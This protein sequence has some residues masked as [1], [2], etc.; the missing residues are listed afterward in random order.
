MLQDENY[1]SNEEHSE[2]EEE[3]IEPFLTMNEI[4]SCSISNW[5]NLFDGKT[6]NKR[7]TLLTKIL[8]LPDDFINYLLQDGVTLPKSLTNDYIPNFSSDSEDEKEKYKT[9]NSEEEE[10]L[11]APEFPKLQFEISEILESYE[12]IF[13]KLN[14][15]AP[16]DAQFMLSESK[17][18]KCSS[19]S[20]IFLV[21]KSSNFISHDLEKA[22]LNCIDYDKELEVGKVLALRKWYDIHPANE[23]RCFIRNKRLIGISQ[24]DD[25]NFYPFL[26]EE[27]EEIE[28]KLVN[29]WESYIKD[30]FPLSRYT[31]DLYIT[32]KG[33]VFIIDFNVYGPPTRPL[34][35]EDWNGHLDVNK[36]KLNNE[37]ENIEELEK[38]TELIF[39][40]VGSSEKVMRPSVQM[41]SGVPEDFFSMENVEKM[42]E[43]LEKQQRS[44]EK[45]EKEK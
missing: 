30:I 29:F 35:F 16:K 45:E 3:E 17:L 32:R 34:L 38:D 23:F 5:Y 42:Q 39:K 11:S 43:F 1:F 2:V 18:L 21:L 25:A 9:N 40:L 22:Y 37:I 13:P 7:I 28:E 4:N 24:R 10:E 14:W 15:S 19:L 41:Y 33:N 44:Q 36:S 31:V 8:H 26:L 6:N 27:K 20:D 12:H